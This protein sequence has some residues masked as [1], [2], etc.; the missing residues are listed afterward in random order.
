MARRF[1]RSRSVRARA[2]PRFSRRSSRSSGSSGFLGKDNLMDMAMA[3]GYGALRS[4]VLPDG[5][6][7]INETLK[8]VLGNYS[9]E[10]SMLVGAWAANQFVPNPLA[11]K[12][13]K[14]VALGEAMRIGSGIANGVGIQQSTASSNTLDAYQY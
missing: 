4:K 13:A 2:S 6:P 12:A 9:D 10:G 5:I 14:I 1:K 7:F 11:K 8:P 3:A